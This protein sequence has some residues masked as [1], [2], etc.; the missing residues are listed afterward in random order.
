[1]PA[2]DSGSDGWPLARTHNR[3]QFFMAQFADPVDAG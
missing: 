1:M 3:L 2:T